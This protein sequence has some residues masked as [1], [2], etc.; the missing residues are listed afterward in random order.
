MPFHKEVAMLSWQ[1]VQTNLLSHNH[2]QLA[3]TGSEMLCAWLD[4]FADDHEDVLQAGVD[5][6]FDLELLP[7]CSSTF[8]PAAAPSRPPVTVLQDA[9]GRTN[10]S[11]SSVEFDP[12]RIALQLAP[13]AAAETAADVFDAFDAF[14]QAELHQSN[15][16]QMRQQQQQQQQPH[17]GRQGVACEPQEQQQQQQ[18]YTLLCEALSA[19]QTQQLEL[20]GEQLVLAE[21]PSAASPMQCCSSTST[22]SRSA[23]EGNDVTC[24]RVGSS[25]STGSNS[26]ACFAPT[27]QQQPQPSTNA[28]QRLVQAWLSKLHQRQRQQSSQHL[29]HQGNMQ[30][31]GSSSKLHGAAPQRAAASGLLQAQARGLLLQ[32]VNSKL[33][34]QGSHLSFARRKAFNPL[35]PNRQLKVKAQMKVWQFGGLM[36]VQLLMCTWKLSYDL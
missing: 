1:Q 13:A 27:P 21:K 22:A 33:P 6:M 20:A 34:R 28:N 23:H 30:L 8:D 31:H 16:Q 26:S 3:Q 18:L 25:S 17:R 19:P 2:Q 15:A 10:D 11:G 14:L 32:P 29:Q 35:T 4:D 24:L 36:I 7:H 12:K 9:N 5:Q